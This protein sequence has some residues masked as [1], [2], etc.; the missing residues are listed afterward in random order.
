MKPLKIYL[1][2]FFI[3]LLFA[4][5]DDDPVSTSFF[6]YDGQTYTINKGYIR[7]STFE[8]TLMDLN[9]ILFEGSLDLTDN[10]IQGN[11]NYISFFG[12]FPNTGID[13]NY[14]L[15]TTVNPY[16]I[17]VYLAIDCEDALCTN[18]FVVSSIEKFSITLSGSN[19][20]FDFD[21]TL[22]NGKSVNG[23][24]NGLLTDIN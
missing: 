1:I 4:C 23:I 16:T 11:G 18:N 14:T 5:K 15:L 10:T 9:V 19:Y 6:E 13:G 22:I 8:P 2:V 21:V 3:A 17:L 7:T 24:Y 20:S 12:F